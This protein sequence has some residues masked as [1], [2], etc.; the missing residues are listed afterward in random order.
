[1]RTPEI[2]KKHAVVGWFETPAQLFAACERLRDA[3]YVHFDAHTPFPVHGLEKAMGLRP[4]RLP[5]I[6]LLCGLFGGV[7]GFVMQWWMSAVDYPQVISG[8][9]AFSFQAFV[10]ITFELTI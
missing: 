9:P 1:M 7:G 8:K 6:V 5:W 3:G 4:S 2:E 10:P